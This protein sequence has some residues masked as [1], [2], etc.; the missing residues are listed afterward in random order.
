[1]KNILKDGFERAAHDVDM[2]E[3]VEWGMDDYRQLV[4]ESEIS[5]SMNSEKSLKD[6][7]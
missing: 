3:L 7:F 6:Y 4:S 1:M 2:L 5:L